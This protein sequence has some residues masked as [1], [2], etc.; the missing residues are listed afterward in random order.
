MADASAGADRGVTV[1]INYLLLIGVMVLLST[2]LLVSTSSYVEGQ[3]ERATG[4]EF[5]MIGNQVASDL[6][7]TDRLA[8]TV[9]APGGVE[10]RIDLPG[11]VAGT[12]YRI[13]ITSDDDDDDRYLVTL[14]STAPDVSVS[15]PVRSQTDI[16]TGGL[17]GDDLIVTYDPSGSGRLEVAN[18]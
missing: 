10:T 16:A 13:E 17:D 18:A 4:A 2:G 7:A 6:A 3:Q 14:R 9:E 11:Q 1:P 5:R 8:R 12:A 15:V